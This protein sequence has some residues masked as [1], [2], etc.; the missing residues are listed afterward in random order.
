VG[1][2]IARFAHRSQADSAENAID[3]SGSRNGFVSSA[4]AGLNPI[5]GTSSILPQESRGSVS[6][7]VRAREAITSDP[8]VFSDGTPDLAR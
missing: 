2:L 8:V 1:V 6:M 7:S 5:A 3:E 4:A